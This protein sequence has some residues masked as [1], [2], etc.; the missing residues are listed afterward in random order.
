MYFNPGWD[1]VYG[2]DLSSVR[3]MA[4]TE[5]LVDI[6]H[7]N[8]VVTNYFK[9]KEID[10]YTVTVDDLSFEANF[11]LTAKR[12]D[13]IH[14]FLVFFNVEFSKAFKPLGFSTCKLLFG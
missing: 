10:L 8:Q 1:N 2:F 11:I 5:P 13:Y 3:Q 12:N 7:P 4:V 6:V 9:F 14:A